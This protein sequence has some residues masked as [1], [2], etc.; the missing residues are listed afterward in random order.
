MFGDG[1]FMRNLRL[2]EVIMMPPN[3]VGLV[4][5]EEEG[6]RHPSPFHVRTQAES[7]I[8]KSGRGCS[9]ETACGRAC[10]GTFQPPELGEN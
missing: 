1:A 7:I 9:L 3:L 6:D 10:S 4:A 8:C 5:L 2:G